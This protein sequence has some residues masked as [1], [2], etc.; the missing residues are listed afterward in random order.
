MSNSNIGT[1]LKGYIQTTIKPCLTHRHDN[2][3]DAPFKW[4]TASSSTKKQSPVQLSIKIFESQHPSPLNL[5]SAP[6]FLIPP[7]L[8]IFIAFAVTRHARRVTAGRLGK[9]YHTLIPC[10]QCWD[11]L[12]P[13]SKLKYKTFCVPIFLLN[14][15]CMKHAEIGLRLCT[16]LGWK[17]IQQRTLT[18]QR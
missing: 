8:S 2:G 16:I 15:L 10:N 3:L 9:I 18:Q 5:T 11:I 7:H 17:Y 12:S 1:G 13:Q 14:K 6:L 4:F